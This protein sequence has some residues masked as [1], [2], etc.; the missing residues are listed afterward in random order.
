MALDPRVLHATALAEASSRV[1]LPPIA[2]AGLDQVTEFPAVED[3]GGGHPRVPAAVAAYHRHLAEDRPLIYIWHRGADAPIRIL[4]SS[5]TAAAE[6][7]TAALAYPPGAR[8]R[9]QPGA[10]AAADLDTTSWWVPLAAQP[11]PAS[12]EPVG[13]SR[14]AETVLATC[15]GPFSYLLIA[16]PVPPPEVRAHTLALAEA[17]R[18]ARARGSASPQFAA[19]AEQLAQAH[20]TA[21]RAPS[22]GLW[23]IRAFA[24]APSPGAAS[25]VAGAVIAGLDLSRAGLQLAPA[26]PVHTLTAALAAQPPVPALDTPAHP[27]AAGPEALAA[28]TPVPAIEI[29]G[30]RLREAAVFDATAEH[31]QAPG[32]GPSITVGSVLDFAD[33]PAGAFALPLASLNRHALVAGA[34]GAGKSQT[35]RTILEALADLP[36]PVPWLV[37]EP[38]K[39]E[40]AGMAGRLGDRGEVLVIRPGEPDAIPACLNPLE[41]EPGFPLQT[42]LDL[43]R[44][45]FLAAFDAEEPFPQILAHALTRT[46]REAGW[47][48]ALS[49][50][51]PGRY[52]RYPTLT[53]LRRTALN[54]VEEIGYGREVAD[55]VRGFID[56]RLA[57][58]TLGTPGRFFEGGHPLN[59]AALMGRNTVI[60]LE[61]LGNDQDKAFLIGAV[62][63]RVVEHLRRAPRTANRLHHVTVL[64]EAH[65]LLRDADPHT[66][67]G[68]AVELF[69]AMLSEIRAYGE[70]VV[71]AEQIPT[72]LMADVAKNTAIKILHRLPAADDRDRIGA[73]MNLTDNQS[74]HVVS[75]PPGRAAVFADGM[76]RPMH[77]QVPLGEHR[78]HPAGASRTPQVERRSPAC[79]AACRTAPCTL[80][81]ITHATHLAADPGLT[82]WIEILTIAH[83]VG[84]PAPAPAPAWIKTLTS[85]CEPR[86]LGCAIGHLIDRAIDSRYAGLAVHFDPDELA[87][88]LAHSAAHTLA[89][90]TAPHPCD[91]SET[92]WQAGRFRWIDVYRAL[93]AA[94]PADPAHPATADW[95]ARGLHLDGT[96]IAE[97]TASYLAH[98][99]NHTPPRTVITGTEPEPAYQRAATSLTRAGDAPTR[100]RTALAS[101]GVTS[102]WPAARLYPPNPRQAVTR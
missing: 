10:L 85:R 79:P 67:A 45:L 92:E 94:D 20:L 53:A 26:S 18:D 50:P 29:P 49:E 60:E 11:L 72:K 51:L 65:R 81:S 93:T 35:V 48:L 40:Y 42:H 86:T 5:S 91:G 61:D 62:L 64:E 8:G 90:P 27:F 34:T 84:E 30:V 25:A 80:R 74:R 58:L 7:E 22:R 28:L 99:D 100:L 3:A 15:I 23:V 47:D 71:I 70:G 95:R 52:A 43:V 63:I 32:T 12:P 83:L 96:S 77:I 59:L 31:E 24:G 39:A 87:T 56:V 73:T 57:S 9:R 19:A 102:N 13:V 17:E 36:E 89:H 4:T 33:R 75:L 2:D 14:F 55:N 98:P 38:V 6:D 54:V 69:A 78:E 101:L 82:L 97:Q 44:A 16:H 41:P 46:Y 37:V 66:P 68:H 88:H 76:D 21:H 1:G